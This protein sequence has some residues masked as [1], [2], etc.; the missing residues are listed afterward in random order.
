MAPVLR[1]IDPLSV[2]GVAAA[3]ALALFFHQWDRSVTAS[4]R[5]PGMRTL[6]V[7]SAAPEKD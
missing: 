6:V 3:A 7:K 4:L 5:D 1:E 2:V